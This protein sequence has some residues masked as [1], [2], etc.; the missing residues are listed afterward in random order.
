MDEKLRKYVDG[1]FQETPQTKK[2][3]ELKEE[4]LQNLIEKYRDLISE[5]KSEE[6]A[7]NIAVAGIGD[8]NELVKDMNK[9]RSTVDVA[10]MKQKSAMLT[11]IAVMLYI[12]SIVPL[13]LF[14]RNPYALVN[15]VI[16]FIVMITL[17]T[18]LLIYNGMTKPNYV[19]VDDTMVE[20][21]MAWKKEKEDKRATRISISVALWS[22]ILALYFIIS[23]TTFAWYITWI[24]FVIGVAIEAIINIVHS[25]R[26]K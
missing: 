3:V 9:V 18:G 24:I 8:I 12:L 5:G 25:I 22:L 14:L 16:G 6:A 17:A 13:L 19:K 21:F 20:E 7:F 2:V 4:M 26:K 15:G 23:F 10:A 11:S 1:L